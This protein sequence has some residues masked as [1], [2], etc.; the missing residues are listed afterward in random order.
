MW[1]KKLLADTFSNDQVIQQAAQFVPIRM[2]TEKEGRALAQKY[3]VQGLPTIL[4]IDKDGAV[5]GRISGYLPPKDFLD[6]MRKVDGGFREVP[7]LEAALKKDPNDP[8]ANAKM[9]VHLI[10]RDRVM[11]AEA[12]IKKAEKANYS[13]EALARAYYR[14]GDYFVGEEQFRRAADYFK[15]ADATAK[16]VPDRAYAKISLMFCYEDLNDPNAAKK[17]AEELVAM[18]DAPAQYVDEAKEFLKGS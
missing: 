14:I 17:V 6:E 5:A 9:A 7:Q 4:F 15:K 13:G 12:A 3:K 16:S 2:D 10:Y 18:K 1:C 11:Q 8:E